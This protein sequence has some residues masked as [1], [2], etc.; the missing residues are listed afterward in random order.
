MWSQKTIWMVKY[1][2][3]NPAIDS[4]YLCGAILSIKNNLPMN[5]FDWVTSELQVK[6]LCSA[7][8]PPNIP[9]ACVS[10]SSARGSSKQNVAGWGRVGVF[11]VRFP[12]WTGDIDQIIPTNKTYCFVMVWRMRLIYHPQSALM[13]YWLVVSDVEPPGSCFQSPGLETS[14]GIFTFPIL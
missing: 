1:D 8:R 13:N 14:R 12:G 11:V 2:V 10:F 6:W 5:P 3:N 7:L 9:L 4:Q